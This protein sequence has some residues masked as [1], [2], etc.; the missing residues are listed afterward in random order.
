MSIRHDRDLRYQKSRNR[1]KR[2]KTFKTKEN[3][4]KYAK[5]LGLNDYEIQDMQPQSSKRNKF[6]IIQQK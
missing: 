3:A 4:E 1:K 6:R 2:S 5:S